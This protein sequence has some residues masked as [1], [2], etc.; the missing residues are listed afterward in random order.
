MSLL[1]A[2]SLAYNLAI[3][4]DIHV[5]PNYKTTT[6]TVNPNSN[7]SAE[8]QND[9]MM[10]VEESAVLGR[11]MEDPPIALLD[12]FL[13]KLQ[14]KTL[15]EGPLDFIVVPGDIVAH[16]L[17]LDDKDPTV[18]NYELLKKVIQTVSEYFAKYFPNTVI[19]PTLGNNDCKYHYQGLN[20]E[21]RD[22]F[23]SSLFDS[24]FGILPKN[25]ELPNLNQIKETFLYG[26][27][28]RVD[29]DS[30][31]SVL[32]TNTL[33][34]NSK[35]IHT[36]Q[37]SIASDQFVWLENQLS[38]SST[39]KFIITNHIYP[40]A[41]YESKSDNLFDSDSNTRF[42]DLLLKYKDKLVIE[43]SAHDHFTDV[44]YHADSSS[45]DKQYYHNMLVSP[46]ISPLKGHNPGLS[47][48][49][50]DTETMEPQDLKLI[51]LP[52]ER[53]YGWTSIPPVDQLPFRE[54]SMT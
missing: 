14:A 54:V 13:Q 15:A 30:K 12:V 38:E 7:L 42:Y 32:A 21:D 52:L 2:T 5:D 1:A 41:K 28:Y 11:M 33:Y 24:W 44:R 49:S 51:F 48:L 23:Y 25:S 40:G 50:I 8:W 39:R 26:G 19:I 45:T 29:I 20:L 9:T 10:T 17:S 6:R 16:G 37:G 43:L 35:N 3:L 46:S 36:N 22:E 18:G 31:L 34:F 4:N 53:T 47:L 27:Y